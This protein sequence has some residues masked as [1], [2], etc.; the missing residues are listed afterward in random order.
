M[1]IG[2][3]KIRLFRCPLTA[4]AQRVLI[5]VLFHGGTVRHQSI[6]PQVRSPDEVCVAREFGTGYHNTFFLIAMLD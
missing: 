4:Q 6:L 3:S 5:T 2:D 1:C